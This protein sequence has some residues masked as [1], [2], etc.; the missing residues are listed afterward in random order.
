MSESRLYRMREAFQS[1]GHAAESIERSRAELLGMIR[2][3]EA[4]EVRA[5]FDDGE[6]PEQARAQNSVEVAKQ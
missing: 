3:L 5:Q 2:E 1:L 6:R 4:E